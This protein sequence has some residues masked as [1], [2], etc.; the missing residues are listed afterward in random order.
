MSPEL[1]A[2]VNT[3]LVP[4]GL[5]LIMFSMGL[6]LRLGDFGLLIAKRWTVLAGL[7]GQLVLMPLLALSIGWLLQLP[8]QYALGLF[9]LGICP[10]GTTS[11]ALTFV[12]RGNV[13]LAVVLTALSSLIT[14]FSIPILLSWALPHFA[15]GGTIPK[16]S[17]PDVMMQLVRITVLPIA[18]GM[19]IR[20]F[21]PALAD[22]ASRWL[23]PVSLIVLIAVI[24]FAIGIS[25][26]MVLANLVGAGPAILLLNVAAMAAGLG[27][28]R[29]IRASDADA[30]TLAIEV[31]VHNVTLATFL[32]LTVLDSLPLAVT[33]NIYGVVMILNAMLLIRWFRPRLAGAGA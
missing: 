15:V 26:D 5:M 13:A 11:N 27:I 21:L 4:I 12:G 10:A 2:F 6:T 32:T 14:V 31:G 9:I 25:I 19:A 1:I 17:I 30:M 22:R 3:G 23:R 20:R 29:L 28:A 33:Q 16:L 8:P 18:I 24:A 7:G